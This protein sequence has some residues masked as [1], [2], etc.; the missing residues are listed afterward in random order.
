MNLLWSKIPCSL[1]FFMHVKLH[2]SIGDMKEA[3]EIFLRN[4]SSM[5][6]VD[7]LKTL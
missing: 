1:Y 6:K 4:L 7:M 5:A 2:T 3:D